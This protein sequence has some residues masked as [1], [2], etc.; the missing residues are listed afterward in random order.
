MRRNVHPRLLFLA[1]TTLKPWLVKLSGVTAALLAIYLAAG[2]VQKINPPEKYEVIVTRGDVEELF[3][4][5]KNIELVKTRPR[6]FTASG[7]AL[8]ETVGYAVLTTDWAPGVKGYNGRIPVLTALD[9]A[10]RIREIRVLDND[11]TIAYVSYIFSMEYLEKFKGK[12]YEDAFEIGKDIDA[13]SGA[14]VSLAA[15]AGSVGQTT[16]TFAARVLGRDVPGDSAGHRIFDLRNIVVILLFALGITVFVGK[17]PYPLVGRIN[18]RTVMLVVSLIVLGFCFRYF[19]TISDVVK[20]TFG[21]TG[22]TVEFPHKFVIMGLAAAG[23]VLFGRFYC[24]FICPYGALQEILYKISPFKGSVSP[25]LDGRLRVTKYGVLFLVPVAYGLTHRFDV[26]NI[27]PFQVTFGSLTS[28]SFF[29]NMLGSCF[30]CVVFAAVVLAAALVMERFFCAYFCPLGALFAVLS[31]IK[32][33][34]KR[35]FMRK[36]AVCKDCVMGLPDIEVEC[37]LCGGIP[38]H[39]PD[40]E[41]NKDA[42]NA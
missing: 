33:I 8:N 22:G 3:P 5:A 4:S 27:E 25:K 30:I 10:G 39:E 31:F 11:E 13:V 24:S 6:Y 20:I 29:S 41:E 32:I 15:L 35:L 37:F 34:P 2:A 16:C 7:G 26:F 36:G 18:S 1:G 40:G 17:V 19:V 21:L 23:A 38:E 9:N 14:T 42:D 28:F 12:S